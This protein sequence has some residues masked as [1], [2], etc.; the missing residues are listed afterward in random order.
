MDP[1]ILLTLM[2]FTYAAPIIV[3]YFKYCYSDHGSRSIS[4]IIT[5]QEPFFVAS[6]AASAASAPLEPP[7]F[8][9]QTKYFITACMMIMAGLTI[10]YEYHRP[11]WSMVAVVAILTGI[12]GVILIPEQFPIHYLFAGTVFFAMI[13]F[14]IGHTYYGTCYSSDVHDTLRIILYTQ[15]LFMI[16]TIN[17]VIQDTHIFEIEALFILNFAIYYLYI[18]FNQTCSTPLVRACKEL[19]SDDVSSPA[20]DIIATASADAN[21]ILSPSSSSSSSTS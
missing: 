10:A 18:H 2:L 1:N 6:A 13:G 5:S 17:G 4:S 21:G 12:F 3:V 8:I 19:S 15:F 9:F 7:F 14:M 16:M 20:V 11:W